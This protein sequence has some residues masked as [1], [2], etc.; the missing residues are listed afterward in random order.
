V[1]IDRGAVWPIVKTIVFLIVLPGTVLVYVPMWIL[2]GETALPRPFAGLRA[3]AAVPIAIGTAVLL[4]S[5]WAFAIVGRGTPA[6][7]DPPRVLVVEG[8][9]RYVRN[10]MYVAVQFVLLGEAAGF[11]STE[12]IVWAATCLVF[13]HLFVVLY[14]E[15]ALGQKFGTEYDDYRRQ[16]PRWIPRLRPV[17]WHR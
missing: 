12:L 5:A 9:Y 6:P 15:P 11:G 2:A 1:A 16:V 17:E 14:E 10:P 4:R 8:L 7:I 13:M 3:L